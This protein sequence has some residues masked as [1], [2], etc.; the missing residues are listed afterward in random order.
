MDMIW[1]ATLDGYVKLLYDN[2]PQGA[3]LES[4]RNFEK[5]FCQVAEENSGNPDVA[6]V[7][8]RTGLQDEY[9]RLYM[10]SISR[11]N[12][13]NAVSAEEQPQVFDYRKEQRLPSVHEFLNNYR[14]VYEEIRPNAREATNKAYEKLFEV[15]KRTDDLIEAQMI[16][17]REKLI[18]NTVIAD[19]KELAED[20]LKAADPNYEITS[21]VVKLSAGAYASANS[22]DEITYMGEIARGK[23]DDLAVQNLVKTELMVQF[24]ALIYAWEHAKRK[25]REGGPRIGDFAKA[26]VVAREKTRSCYRLM[27]RD[28]GIDFDKIESTPFYRIML[29]DPKGLDELWRIKKVM[30]PENIKATK[31]VLFEEILTERS[32][33]DILLSSQQQPY[34]EPVDTI[35]DAPELE[36]EYLAIAAE[37]NKDI[38]YF[39]RN[40]TDA[41]LRKQRKAVKGGF[42]S[43]KLLQNMKQLNQTLSAGAGA[44]SAGMTGGFAGGSSCMGAASELGTAAGAVKNMS[45][46]MKKEFG[47]STAKSTAATAAKE[48]GRGLLRSFFRK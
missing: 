47:K 11:N 10:A 38:P 46:D 4:I 25:I 30:H 48:V 18:L 8:N 6:G 26:M 19:Y 15:E 33:E 43:E 9:N 2:D 16:I 39:R 3:L 22:L 31:Y 35:Y 1:Q 36:D 42:S 40:R 44:V 5:R 14:L 37:L 41:E 27:S 7:L 28:M 17:E 24:M 32:L 20:F 45:P 34:Y 13:Y 21:S 29:L 12:E 23:A